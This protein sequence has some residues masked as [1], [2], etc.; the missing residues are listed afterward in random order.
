MAGNVV[1]LSNDEDFLVQAARQ[2]N[3]EAFNQLVLTYQGQVFALAYRLLGD[4]EQAADVA[5][6]TFLSAFQ[7]IGRFQRGY[8]RAWLL[9]IATNLCYDALRRRRS[10]PTAP[11]ETLLTQP[12]ASELHSHEAETDPETYAEQQELAQ[13]IQRALNR[14][15]PEQ[16]A[17]VVLCDNEGF[18]YAE[19]AQILGISLGTLKSRLSRGRARL[20]D[21][22]LVHRELLPAALRSIVGGEET[23]LPAEKPED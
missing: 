17:A 6:E 5:Q 16:R 18:P 13:E 14:L 21:Y 2:G 19:A 11:L 10:R 22:F 9:R 1:A 8:L 7:H 3:L 15:P 20:R 4:R 23:P 12:D